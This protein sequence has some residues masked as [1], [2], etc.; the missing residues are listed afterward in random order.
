MSLDVLRMA[1]LAVLLGGSSAEREVSLQSGQTVI[2]ALRAQGFEVRPVDPASAD[3]IAG[4]QGGSCAL[5][6]L[7]GPGGWGG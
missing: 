3:W 4:L 1:P 6:A 2:D 5:I 7:R